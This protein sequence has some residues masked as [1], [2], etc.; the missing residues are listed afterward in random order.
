LHE[1]VWFSNIDKLVEKKIKSCIACLNSTPEWK[2][3]PLQMSQ[4]PAAPW[5]EISVDFAN[6][7]DQEYM[8]LITDDYSRYPVVEILKST[9]AAMEIRK[10]NKVFSEFGVP[11]VV[12]SDNGPPF[13]S[14]S[15]HL[16][17]TLVL[18]IER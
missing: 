17:S 5:T 9:T 7:P 3:E 1:K 11:D 13:N 8:L 2:R 4:L 18:S 12:K 10:L 15:R 16:Q 6:L 14:N